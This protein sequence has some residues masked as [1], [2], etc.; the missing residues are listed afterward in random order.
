MGSKYDHYDIEI[1]LMDAVTGPL[2]DSW[3][4][5]FLRTDHQLPGNK[6]TKLLYWSP[7]HPTLVN[8]GASLSKAEICLVYLECFYPLH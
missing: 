1:D 7:F 3:L 2:L 5:L 4:G 6:S 8:R